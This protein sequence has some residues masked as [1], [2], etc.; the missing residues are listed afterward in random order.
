MTTDEQLNNLAKDK[1]PSLLDIFKIIFA[2]NYDTKGNLKKNILTKTNLELLIKFD[3]NEPL[4]TQELELLIKDIEVTD[5]TLSLLADIVAQSIG[6]GECKQPN[7]IIDL[8]VSISSQVWINHH[9]GEVNLFEYLLSSYTKENYSLENLQI[10]I[11]NQYEARLRGTSSKLEKASKDEN[12]NTEQNVID[13]KIEENTISKQKESILTIGFYWLITTQE[14]NIDDNI[15]FLLDY[16]YKEKNKIIN[17][18]TVLLTLINQ[19][20]KSD[21]TISQALHYLHAKERAESEKSTIFK[22]RIDSLQ[23][24]LDEEKKSKEKNIETIKAYEKNINELQ[25]QLKEALTLVQDQQLDQRAKRTHLKDNER[26]AK[27]KAYNL[28][29]EEVLEPLR[30]SLAA[31]SRERPKTEIAI[32]NIENIIECVEGDLECFKE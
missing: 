10:N 25:E 4:D 16:L 17:I 22:S 3:S 28:L 5:P 21:K 12:S 7:V 23:K 19:T 1:K 9:S 24:E 6:S 29:A 26:Q 2:V 20:H 15:E 32:Y 31:L 18:R 11:N 27:A 13:L 30:L 14:L 8:A